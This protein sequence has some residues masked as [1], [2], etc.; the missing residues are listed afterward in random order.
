VNFGEGFKRLRPRLV[1]GLTAAVLTPGLSAG[2]AVGGEVLKE[3]LTSRPPVVRVEERRPTDPSAGTT[4]AEQLYELAR[5]N[6]ERKAGAIDST[7]F[8][9]ERQKVL[10]QPIVP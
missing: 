1:A 2:W 5:L 7:E 10:S 8:E 6:I 9:V 3:D 4:Y